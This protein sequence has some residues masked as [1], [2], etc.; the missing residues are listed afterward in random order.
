[1]QRNCGPDTLGFTVIKPRGKE[2]NYLFIDFNVKLKS[3]GALVIVS[4]TVCSF[5]GGLKVDTRVLDRRVVD[6]QLSTLDTALTS[7]S[8]L[9]ICVGGVSQLIVPEFEGQL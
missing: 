1:M 3:E 8:Y 6:G 5:R 7:L 2:Q 9:V 4:A